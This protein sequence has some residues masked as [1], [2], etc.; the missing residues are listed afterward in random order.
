MRQDRHWSQIQEKTS[1]WGL[2]FVLG[3]LRLTGRSCINILL[4]P[5][6][7]VYWLKESAFRRYSRQYLMQCYQAGILTQC[8]GPYSSFSHLLFFAHTMLDKLAFLAGITEQNPIRFEGLDRV[9]HFI[10]KQQGMIIATSHMG[11]IEALQT[12]G[13]ALHTRPVVA[14]VYQQHSQHFSQLLRQLNP[15]V[16][17]EFWDIA[18]LSPQ[19]AICLEDKINE[20]ALVFIA[21]D[22]VPSNLNNSVSVPFLQRNAR[23]PIGAVILANLFHCPLFALNCRRLN[24][25][26]STYVMTFTE[27]S[28]GLHLPRRGR[29]AAIQALMTKYVAAL[30]A[31]IRKSPLDWSNFYDYWQ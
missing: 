22:R 8:P 28:D 1:S 25:S 14:L 21:A 19:T 31:N 5:I 17:I 27:L 29:Q 20:G 2:R 23:F 6:V 12:W 7:A 9:N 3:L 18:D 10:S 15:L 13:N 24:H 11:C 30:E 4:Y 26:N 16:H